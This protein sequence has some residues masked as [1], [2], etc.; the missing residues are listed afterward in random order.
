MRE[1]MLGP[2]RFSDLRAALPG[3]SANVLTQRLEGLE[4][5][6]VV[7]RR[8]LPPPAATRV[9]ELTQWGAEAE[10]IFQA[11]GRWAAR[12]PRHDPTR[13]F[14]T[15][16]LVLSLRTMFSAERAKGL[17]FALALKIGRETFVVRVT[18]GALSVE[19]GDAAGAAAVLEGDARAIAGAIYGGVPLQ[20]LEASGAV[21]ANGDR[22]LL[23]RFF[24]LFPLPP[25]A[26]APQPG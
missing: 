23:S 15:N 26:E 14:S 6:G 11:L 21:K 9:Y 4:D 10:P 3:I 2:K 8:E 22:A 18:K 13:P 16:S 24:T 25:K 7:V 12:S 20:A 5:V 17:A 19:R 1:L